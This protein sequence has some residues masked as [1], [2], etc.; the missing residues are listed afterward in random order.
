[1]S[2]KAMFIDPE[3][4]AYH[5]IDSLE[6]MPQPGTGD[7]ERAAKVRLAAYLSTYF[8][9]EKFNRQEAKTFGTKATTA[10]TER[11]Y[12]DMSFSEIFR[13]VADINEEATNI[14]PK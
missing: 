12:E 9:I 3:K 5:F 13:K 6:K 4:F 8:L 7:L 2:D 1:M 10:P 14:L 11:S